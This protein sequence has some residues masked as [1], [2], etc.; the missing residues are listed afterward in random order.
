MKNIKS[1]E[2][3]LFF[4]GKKKTKNTKNA[5]T[6]KKKGQRRRDSA[7]CRTELLDPIFFGGWGALGPHGTPWA[8]FFLIIIFIC[9]M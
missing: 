1:S 6:S 8:P 9:F 3:S 5:K 2:K 7:V 4:W